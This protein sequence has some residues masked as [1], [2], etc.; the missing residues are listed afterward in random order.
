MI[1]SANGTVALAVI[2]GLIALTRTAAELAEPHR[3]K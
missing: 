2:G 1:P 3:R